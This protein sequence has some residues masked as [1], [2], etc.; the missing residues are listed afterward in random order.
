MW[1]VTPVL[2]KDH[3]AALSSKPFFNDLVKYM[4]SGP[5]VPMVRWQWMLAIAFIFLGPVSLQCSYFRL[6]SCPVQIWSS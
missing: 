6:T 5:V 1:Q 2:L 3:Y 4:S